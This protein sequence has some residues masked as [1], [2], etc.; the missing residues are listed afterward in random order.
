[1]VATARAHGI[2]VAL[3]LAIQCSADHPWLTEHPEWFNR[4]PDGTLKYAENRPRSTRTS[5]NVNWNH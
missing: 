5:T 3:D 4:R 2:D 1:M